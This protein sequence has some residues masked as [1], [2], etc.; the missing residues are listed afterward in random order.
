V[1]DRIDAI[2]PPGEML[3]PVDAGYDP[4]PITDATARRR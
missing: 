4:P 3:N 2:V 1:L